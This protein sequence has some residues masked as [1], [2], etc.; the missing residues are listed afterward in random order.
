MK[1]NLTLALRAPLLCS[2]SNI[3][4]TRIKAKLLIVVFSSVLLVLSCSYAKAQD[5]SPTPTPTEEEQQLQQEKKLFEL[6][7]DIELAKKAI[8][9]AQPEKTEPAKPTA[10]PLEGNAVLSEGVRF[11]T[12]MVS[13][14]AMSEVAEQISTEISTRINAAKNIAIYDAQVVKDWRFY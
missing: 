1:C 2:A 12:E 4:A 8:R 6:K 9:D 5:T 14:K 7:R 3:R 11:E 10:T 13:Y